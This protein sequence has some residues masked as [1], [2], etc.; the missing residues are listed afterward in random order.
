MDKLKEEYKVNI[1]KIQKKD[2]DIFGNISEDKTKIKT[3]KNNKHREIEKDKFKVLNINLETSL[4][5]F[6]N[7]LKELRTYLE[8]EDN[9]IEIPY[10]LPLYK[11]SNEKILPEGFNKFSLSPFETLDELEK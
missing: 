3:L 2:F 4:D 8:E 1:E 6:I 5:S 10:D 7:K 9:K 11:A